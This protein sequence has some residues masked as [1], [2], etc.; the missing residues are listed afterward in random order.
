ML[1]TIYFDGNDI[2]ILDQTRLPGEAIYKRINSVPQAAE[3]IKK[4]KIRGAPLIGVFAAFA[5]AQDMINYSGSVAGLEAHFSASKNSLAATR[6]TAVNLFWAIERMDKIFRQQLARIG[7]GKSSES[8]KTNDSRES[9][10]CRGAKDCTKTNQDFLEELGQALKAEALEMYHEDIRANQAMGEFGQELL[11]ENS[12]ILTICNAGALATCGHG[13]A[14]GVIRSA[15][16]QGKVDM[17]YACETRPLLQGS[18]LTVWELMEDSVPVTLITDNMAGHTIKTKDINAIIAG[19]D[20]IAA[21]GDTANKIGTSTLAVLADYYGV[22]FYIAAPMSTI[23]E[24]LTTGAEIP[25]EERHPEE[26]RCISDNYITV[27]E[28][29]VYSPAFDVTP[30]E[31][32]TAII[33]EKGVFR[34]PFSF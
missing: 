18:R 7:G 5:L 10:D 1:K 26:V 2:M 15:A 8:A 9:G 23:N 24:K 12:R 22:P 27:P 19:A 28:V 21:N 17:V 3:A 20:C 14:L 31:L 33:T 34:K 25:I 29:P 13:T 16:A 32:I 6:P 11:P 4:L 30:N